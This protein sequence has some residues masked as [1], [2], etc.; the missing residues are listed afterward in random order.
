MI[1]KALGGL[2]F[3]GL[4][5]LIV[6]L[7]KKPLNFGEFRNY[8]KSHPIFLNHYIFVVF[9]RLFL[10]LDLIILSSNKACGFVAIGIAALYTLFL[11]IS[12][13]YLKNVRPIINMFVIV[14]ILVIESVYKLNFYSS[15]AQ[16]MTS[17][18]PLF[19]VIALLVLLFINVV[20]MILEIR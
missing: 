8:F 2:L 7:Y 19:I 20:F 16:F 3:V 4:L 17:Y 13:P 14:M 10:A 18:L 6:L 15:D 12:R 11:I 9:F 1:G 5:C